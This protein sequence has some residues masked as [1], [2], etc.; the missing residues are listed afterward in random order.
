MC[1][2]TLRAGAVAKSESLWRALHTSLLSLAGLRLCKRHKSA[3]ADAVDEFQK[4][5]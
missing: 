4:S 2:G 3:G 1:A 5:V